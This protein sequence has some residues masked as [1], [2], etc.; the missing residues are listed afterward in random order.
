MLVK[1][2]IY[3]Y[4][5]IYI[6]ICVCVCVC[7]CVYVCEREGKGHTMKYKDTRL[8]SCVLWHMK[9]AKSYLFIYIICK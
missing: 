8:D 4:N 7:V 2:Y 3:I 9:P 6:Y 5:F 1:L